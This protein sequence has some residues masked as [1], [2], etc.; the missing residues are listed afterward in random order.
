MA[1]LRQRKN[2]YHNLGE[3]EDT[4]EVLMTHALVSSVSSVSSMVSFVRRSK[5]V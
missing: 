2:V 3:S 4:I 1:R 5:G